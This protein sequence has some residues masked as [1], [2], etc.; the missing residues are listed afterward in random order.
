MTRCS[1][2]REERPEFFAGFIDRWETRPKASVI[3]RA[4]EIAE[5][6]GAVIDHGP[7]EPSIDIKA[8]AL[9]NPMRTMSAFEYL[10]R[11]ELIE[12]RQTPI[13]HQVS[14]TLPSCNKAGQLNYEKRGFQVSRMPPTW[15]L[16]L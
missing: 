7:I 1:Q 5:H 15:H 6:F 13:G 10:R 11:S 2:E 14:L 9:S 8:S 12:V 16:S 3:R 4:V